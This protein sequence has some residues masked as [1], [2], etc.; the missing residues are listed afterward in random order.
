MIDDKKSVRFSGDEE[1]NGRKRRWRF[2]PFRRNKEAPE[3]EHT[4]NPLLSDKFNKFLEEDLSTSKA[5]LKPRAKSKKDFKPRKEV[6]L[7]APPAAREAAFGGPPRYDWI[8]IE[9]HAAIKVQAAYRRNKVMNDLERQG[10]STGAI[11]NRARRRHAED[12]NSFLNC[13]GTHLSF[14]DFSSHDSEAHR[15]YQR[16]VYEEQKKAR[17][18]Y[19][20]D[21]RNGFSKLYNLRKSKKNQ[22]D[23][24]YEVVE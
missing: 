20:E 9:T 8:D 11:R 23:E 4:E 18:Q 14:A 3:P 22:L 19:E 5:A 17:Y 12:A 13:C 21:L 15:E 10:V 24:A 2:R 16:L 1:N 7:S 6:F